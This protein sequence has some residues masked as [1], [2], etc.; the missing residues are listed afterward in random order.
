[1]N[2]LKNSNKSKDK[3]IYQK[4]VDTETKNENNEE[5]SDSDLDELLSGL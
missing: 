2:Y 3:R 4:K 1:M 5:I